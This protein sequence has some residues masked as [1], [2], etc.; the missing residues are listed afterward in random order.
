MPMTGVLTLA[1]FHYLAMMF[2]A[3]ALVAEHLMFS[4]RPDLTAARKLVVVDLIYGITLLVALVTG[5]ARMFHGGKG[6]LFYM[7]NGAYHTKFALFILMAA[8][9]IYPAIKF[10]GWRRALGAGRTPALSEGE[11]KRVLIAIR[12]Q[13][14]ILVVIPLLAAMMARGVWS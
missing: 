3:A 10:F 2:L 6:A 14:V 4:P 8:V 7:Q 9:W 13:L 11:A 5:M 12:I 1:W